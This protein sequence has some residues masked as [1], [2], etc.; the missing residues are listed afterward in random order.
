MI[1]RFSSVNGLAVDFSSVDV[2]ARC[3]GPACIPPTGPLMLVGTPDE[4]CVGEGYSYSWTPTTI[5]G[6]GPF[7]YEINIALPPGLT[8]DTGT[9]EISGTPT[10]TGL[11]NLTIQVTDA[12]DNE[13]SLV[14]V[15]PLVD[16]GILALS[17]EPDPVCNGDIFTFAPETTG[18]TAP[19]SYALNTDDGDALPAGLTLDEDT[20]EI[21]GTS[22]ADGTYNIILVVTDAEEATETLSF[23]LV[24][25]EC[26]E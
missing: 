1:R 21:T 16:C 26:G 20:G 13:A 11:V 18:G 3:L 14:V 24:V 4:A 19:Y 6:T 10:E 22:V 12:N 9:G 25:A 2:S 8:F 5:N 15:L 7:T 23:D 17:G